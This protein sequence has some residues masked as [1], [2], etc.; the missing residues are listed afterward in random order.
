[1][2][3]NPIVSQHTKLAE[4]VE[5]FRR[6]A[7]T[8]VPAERG[9]EWECDYEEWGDLYGSARSVLRT[10][11]EGWNDETKHLLIYAI[12]RDNE[13]EILSKEL[14]EEQLLVLSVASMSSDEWA[15]K[16][17]LAKQLGQDP[18][19]EQREKLLLCFASDENEYVRR[20]SLAA[21]ADSGSEHAE[22]L[23]MTAWQSGEEYQQMACLHALWRI[24][25]P[26]LPN[27]LELA[28][29]DNRRYLAEIA[30]RIRNK[31]GEFLGQ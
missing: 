27:Y 5:R 2:S 10:S 4:A 19:T 22:Q 31:T 13:M 17:Q 20:R 29:R 12:A 23:A 8:T 6:W 9:G 24:K 26:L 15:A 11:A 25:S 21:L 18:L 3:A 7:D 30:E 28:A 14:T 16:W 1:M